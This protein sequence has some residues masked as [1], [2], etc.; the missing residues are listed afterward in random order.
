M[1]ETS[2]HILSDPH[3]VK[4]ICCGAGQ[5][6]LRTL[7]HEVRSLE[8][9]LAELRLREQRLLAE[10]SQARAVAVWHKLTDDPTTWPE[11]GALVAMVDAEQSW[12]NKN[13][14]CNAV[15]WRRAYDTVHGWT[16]WLPLPDPLKIT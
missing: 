14:N 13:A 15:Y 6:P 1:S 3:G 8:E 4:G 16:H 12:T 9:Q 11:E 5:K 7:A 10:L 2:D